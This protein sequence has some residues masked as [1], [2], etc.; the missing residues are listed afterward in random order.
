MTV[1]L[2]PTSD[3]V[4]AGSASPLT[5]SQAARADRPG[6]EAQRGTSAARDPRLSF[7]GV[8]AAADV[9][10]TTLPPT[11]AWSY[12]LLDEAAGRKVVVKHENV[13]P[14]G[15]F[16]VRGGLNLLATLP[17]SVVDGGLVTVSTGNHAQ[18]LA[19]A[20]RLRG[21]SATIVMAST[22]APS[23]VAA[24][25]ALGA[26][27]VLAGDN[28]AEAAAEAAALADREGLYFVN[29]GEEPAII[30][31]HATVYLELLSAHPEIET[32][33]VPIGSGSGAAGAVLVRDA[34]AP[35]VRVVGVQAE[36]ARAGYDSWASGSIVQGPIATFAA[37]LATGSGFA[38]P[39]SVLRDGLD[40]FL[41][42]SEG[43]LQDAVI[44]MAGAAHTL[45]EGAGGS[46]LA[47]VLAEAR[48]GD[49]SVAAFACT[50][51]NASSD[52][53]ALLQRNSR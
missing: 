32:L 11:P 9:I 35:H 44:V 50:G 33:Y 10:A 43:Q 20:S 7:E 53:L 42:L 6:V 29:P 40:D 24:V 2:R 1:T 4:A 48:G 49:D 38:A 19:Y 41:L 5:G 52:E 46:G 28:M 8:L 21:A 34:I 13:Q 17:A 3:A 37:G 31:G 45:C 22:T 27:V 47:G 12:P 30:H 16:K 15:A 18:S 26:R 51:G 39:Q 23:K 14:T 36:G 25:R